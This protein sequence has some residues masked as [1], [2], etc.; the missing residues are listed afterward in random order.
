[1][2]L[3]LV[4]GSSTHSFEMMLSAFILGIALGGLWVHRRIDA[5][6]DQ[7]RFLANILMMM[8]AIALLSLPIYN[9]TF[10]LMSQVIQ[11]FSS[12]EQGYVGISILSHA[13][14]MLVMLPTTFFCGM[15]LPVM[16]NVLIRGGAGERAIGSVYA[17]N[18]AGAIAGVIV[19][20][21]FLMPTI[22]VKGLVITGAAL[23]LSLGVV[24]RG[25]S[26][27][28]SSSVLKR[29]RVPAMVGAAGIVAAALFLQ[30]D[31]AKLTSGVFRHGRASNA[32]RARVLLLDHGK[33]ATVSLT[34]SDG[35][36]SIA[37]NGKPDA[38]INMRAGE[39]S[40]AADEITMVL[41]GALPYA[42]HPNPR[43][44]ATIGIG[45]GLTTQVLLANPAVQQV[46]TVEIE[47]AMANAARI[48]FMPRVARTFTD[49]RSHI[50]FEDAK[51]FFALNRA[52]Y[53]V[54]VS[55]PSNPWVSGV[56]TLFSQEFYRQITRYLEP[57]GLLVQWFQIYEADMDIVA[58]VMKAMA[59]EFADFAV[60]NAD[61]SNILIVATRSGVLPRSASRAFASSALQ[62]ELARV[63]LHRP[64]D[65][66]SR[67]LG[68]KKLLM[69]LLNAST[70]PPNSAYFPF[71]D[72][73]AA[74]ARI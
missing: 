40:S 46:D 41:A 2:M 52:K 49:P 19:A 33:T 35:Y 18:T 70:A 44:M 50:H 58:S 30:L 6:A 27:S 69:P 54:I 42:L 72:L 11:T 23:H 47:P 67:F 45:S 20:V 68:D 28:S 64:E 22:G 4:L 15:T 38:T 25:L 1:R 48:G 21:H 14:A 9:G 24:Y 31:P 59:P 43:R 26:G 66:E 56:A 36:I 34:D 73:H 62:A 32:D 8:A 12:S 60:Y 29:L 39:P 7:V 13:I 57:D 53:D 63:G 71:V 10:D 61:D 37:T 5:L 65:I 3:S 51:T 16:T 55:E 17:W 74:R